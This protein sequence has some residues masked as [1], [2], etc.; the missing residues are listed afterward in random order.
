MP[1]SPM[2]GPTRYTP[3]SEPGAR[4]PRG[5]LTRTSPGGAPEPPSVSGALGG[6]GVVDGPT[7]HS[8]AGGGSDACGGG[9]EGSASSGALAVRRLS[10]E[11]IR[12]SSLSFTAH[13]SQ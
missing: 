3:N 10:G 5:V 7:T 9:A 12:G 2:H 4:I 8:V 6:G 13:H 1:P 11:K